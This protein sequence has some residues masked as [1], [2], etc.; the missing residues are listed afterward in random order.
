[1]V[2]ISTKFKD[3][4]ENFVL[5]YQQAD[6]IAAVNKANTMNH[7][8]LP[9]D[10]TRIQTIIKSQGLKMSDLLEVVML[11]RPSWHFELPI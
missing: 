3:Y 8:P 9:L 2:H 7:P 1:M 5:T 4:F 10:L 6:E 11:D